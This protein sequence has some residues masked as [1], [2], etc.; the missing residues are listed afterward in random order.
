MTEYVN[1]KDWKQEH[2]NQLYITVMA[3]SMTTGAVMAS[4]ETR[5]PNLAGY[6]YTMQKYEAQPIEGVNITVFDYAPY[7]PKFHYEWIARTFYGCW[8][9]GETIKNAR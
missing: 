2:S 5:R 9:R 1:A 4:Y 6:K 8:K 7:F 3:K